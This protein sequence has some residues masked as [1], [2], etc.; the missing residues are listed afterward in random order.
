MEKV[1]LSYSQ[2]DRFFAELLQTK[3]EGEGV[4]VW[5]DRSALRGGDEWRTAI[6][7][8]ISEASVIIFV[9]SI[10]SCES[11]YVTYE[12]ASGM[13]KG[14]PV[15]P[16]LIEDCARHPKIEPIQYLDLRQHDEASWQQVV[17]RVKEII[18]GKE[19]VERSEKTES[20]PQKVPL[21]HEDAK[22]RDKIMAYLFDKGYRMMSF[23]RIQEKI[24][25]KYTDEFLRDLANRVD[26]FAIA[27]LKGPR[28]GIKLR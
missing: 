19:E 5:R 11:H 8:G 7:T 17:R 4:E 27:Y 28:V 2:K 25:E 23:S 1:F 3:L 18:S 26:E 12:W 20:A 16:I 22:A 21:T 13:G 14:K 9:A 10:A 24:D 15:L 6:D